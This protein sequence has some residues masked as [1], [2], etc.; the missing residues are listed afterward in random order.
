MFRFV[1]AFLILVS[2]IACQSQDWEETQ[3]HYKRHDHGHGHGEDHG[4]DHTGDS[5][6]DH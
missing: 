1:S 3:A 2:L 5:N 6:K 4:E